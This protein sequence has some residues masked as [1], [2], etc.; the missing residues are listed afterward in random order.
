LINPLL[1]YQNQQI[2]EQKMEQDQKSLMLS[3]AHELKRLE[4]ESPAKEVAGR[5]I[6][7]NGLGYITAIILIGVSASIVLESDKI[8]AVMGL[9]SAALMAVIQMVNGVAG[10]APKQERPEFVVIQSLIERLDKLDRKE[11]AM[12]VTVIDGQVTVVK[13]D[14]VI[15]TT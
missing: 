5:S 4:I 13:G 10:T 11:P 8:A 3:Q 9:L 14:D 7:K 12:K 2:K 15:S 6:G 1:K